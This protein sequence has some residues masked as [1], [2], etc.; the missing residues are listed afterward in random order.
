MLQT[1]KMKK[2][3]ANLTKLYGNEF[4]GITIVIFN[5]IFSILFLLLL[6]FL[7]LKI[8]SAILTIL[9]LLFIVIASFIGIANNQFSFCISNDY[10]IIR[11]EYLLFKKERFRICIDEIERLNYRFNNSEKNGT[12]HISIYSKINKK[13]TFKIISSLSNTESLLSTFKELNIP[14]TFSNIQ[15]SEQRR[16]ALKMAE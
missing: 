5:S 14:V 8:K 11:N 13:K 15:T 4:G 16:F 1:R 10:L 9:F 12:T 2:N 3:N 7:F 6:I